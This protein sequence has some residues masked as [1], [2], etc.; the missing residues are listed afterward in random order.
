MAI[1]TGGK[2][3][4]ALATQ[5]LSPPLSTEYRGEGAILRPCPGPSSRWRWFGIACFAVATCLLLTSAPQT[6]AQ[7]ETSPAVK[8]AVERVDGLAGSIRYDG[9]KIVGVRADK[10]PANDEDVKVF[11]G[12]TDLEE[13]ALRGEAVTDAAVGYLAGLPKLYHLS[14]EGASVTDDGVAKLRQI[15][16][17]HV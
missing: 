14:F 8:A 4:S 17:A 7:P 11:A 10:N 9:K 1:R 12:L 15:G 3:T 16:R 5:P 6:A 2:M 13:L